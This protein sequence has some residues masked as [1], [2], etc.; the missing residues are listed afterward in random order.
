MAHREPP[1]LQRRAYARRAAQAVARDPGEGVERVIEHVRKWLVDRR[2]A[3]AYAPRD[4]W[5]RTLHGWLGVPWPCEDALAFDAA[6]SAATG[7]LEA[8]SLRVGRGAYGGWDDADPAFAVAAW[9]L[10]CHLR[11]ERV[12]E[13]GVARGLVTRCMLEA[14]RRNEAGQLWSIDLPPL[15]ETELEAQTAAAVD[16]P[17]RLRWT[18][19]KGSSRRRLPA[20]LS[21]LASID[22]FVHDSMHTDRN[23]RFELAAA[24]PALRPGGA[25]LVDDVE[26]SGAFAAFTSATAG[27]RSVVGRSADAS[28]LVGVVV[29]DR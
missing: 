9:C 3:P 25:L 29:K 27:Q 24:W 16:G 11:P 2:A 22:L 18:Y 26:Q 5:L 28:A 1:S 4:D 20:L 8:R 14:L 23:V 7:A 17:S 12:V 13:T 15:L 19:V 21:Q 6:W 10:V